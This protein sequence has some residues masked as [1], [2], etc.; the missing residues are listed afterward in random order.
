MIINH[1]H[2]FC[3]FA[4]PRT[5]SKAI[6][7]VLLEKFSSESILRMHSSY[8][9]FQNS[10]RQEELSYFTFTSIRNPL[11]SVVSAY[12]KKK[13]DHNG[14]FSRGTFKRT[15]IPI[16]ERAM[17]EYRFITANDASFQEYFKV[18]YTKPYTVPRHE[19]T[20]KKVDAIIRYEHLNEDFASVT[21]KLGLSF[22][23]IQRVNKTAGKSKDFLQ[24]YTP[25]IIPQA[26][27][28]FTPLMKSWGYNFPKGWI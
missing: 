6:S 7:K 21:E 9:E 27:E 22:Y 24:F 13:M 25:D 10:A 17:E 4:I 11:D 26:I 16:G 5:A 2:R 12:F 8:Q 20:V 3:Y 1:L 28:I 23:P 18:F 15:G 19:N 14:R